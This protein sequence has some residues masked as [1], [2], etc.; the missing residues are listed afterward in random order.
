MKHAGT[1]ELPQFTTVI[2]VGDWRS[3]HL[4]YNDSYLYFLHSF[5][6]YSTSTFLPLLRLKIVWVSTKQVFTVQLGKLSAVLYTTLFARLS[7]G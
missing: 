4:L 5:V 2:R 3:L 7:R 6:P 1:D